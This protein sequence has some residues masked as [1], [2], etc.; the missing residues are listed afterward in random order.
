VIINKETKKIE[1]SRKLW[2]YPW[3]YAESFIIAI[4]I[5]VLGI[6][7]EV[8][9]KGRGISF[10]GL[11]Y[12]LYIILVFAAILIFLHIKYKDSPTVKWISSIPAAISSISIY[13]LLVLLLGFIPQSENESSKF[14]YYSG[15][16]HVKNSWPFVLIQFYFLTVLGMVTLRRIIPFKFKNLGFFLNHFGLWIT[17]LAAGLGSSDLQRLSMNLYEDGNTYNT[18]VAPNGIVY[19]MP[20]SIKLIKF[21]V[22]QYN[23]KLAIVNAQT[24]KY[25]LGNAKLQPFVE[26]GLE[27][28][29]ANWKIK[30]LDYIPLALTHNGAIYASDSVGSFPAAYVYAKNVVTG[31]TARGWIA[32][33]SFMINP[34]YLL[35][36]GTDVLVLSPPEPKKYSSQLIVYTDS[37]PADTAVLEVNKPYSIRNWDIYQTGFDES[38][39]KWSTLSVVEAVND[40]WLPIVYF[41][42]ALLFSG[43]LYLFWIGKDKK[44]KI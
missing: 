38:M 23:P 26:K 6:L 14:L 35:L 7:V 32:S 24:S 29:M 20:F 27:T 31:D 34:V 22:V 8:F 44:E 28:E 17:L 13:A 19:K 16:S 42:I 41:G 11:P 36:K 3:K 25:I 18:A 12:N 2:D 10:P 1:D 40:P 37:K 30:V 4:E 39:G 5:L 33:G 21:D 15:L 9:T 43:A